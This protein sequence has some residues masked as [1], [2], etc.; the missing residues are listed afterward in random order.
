[1]KSLF[2]KNPRDKS[3]IITDSDEEI[4]LLRYFAKIILE[5]PVHA[6]QTLSEFWMMQEATGGI[7]CIPTSLLETHGNMSYLKKHS[8]YE[9]KR[10]T[11]QTIESVIEK[12]IEFGYIH[13]HH[14]GELATYRRE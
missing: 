3:V 12:L 9:L 1:L 5:Q 13:A 4:N 11:E 2:D 14:L 10:G 8:L 6:I 7:F